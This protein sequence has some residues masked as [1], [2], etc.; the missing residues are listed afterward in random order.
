MDLKKPGLRIAAQSLAAARALCLV[1]SCLVNQTTI[2]WAA[3]ASLLAAGTAIA[4]A[5]DGSDGGDSADGG[6]S[7]E[8]GSDSGESGS[9]G[10]EGESDSSGSGGDGNSGGTSGESGDSGSGGSGHSGSASSGSGEIGGH[11]GGH[12]EHEGSG[13][14]Y[15]VSGFLNALQSHGH[16]EEVEHGPGKVFSV[17]YSDGW[18]E[19]VEGG[20]YELVDRSGRVVISR[21]ARTLDEQRLEAAEKSQNWSRR[22][23]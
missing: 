13:S 21:P 10:G 16:V 14:G 6:D 7:G 17:R 8:S 18:T 1:F 11:S 2:T 9:D 20:T 12:R 5:D 23:K 4:H 15:S 19:R 22:G 3:G